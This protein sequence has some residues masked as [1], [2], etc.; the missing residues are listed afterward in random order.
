MAWW[1]INMLC[2]IRRRNEN[3]SDLLAACSSDSLRPIFMSIYH[4]RRQEEVEVGVKRGW[5]GL[6]CVCL[7]GGVGFM[8]RGLSPCS[9][10]QLPLTAAR[11][12]AL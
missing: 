11:V 5:V 12:S 9:N 3:L 4:E 10:Y 1:T 7:R 2:K 8:E 6:R